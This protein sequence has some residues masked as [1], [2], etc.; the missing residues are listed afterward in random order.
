M[1]D[2]WDKRNMKYETGGHDAHLNGYAIILLE[3]L[4]LL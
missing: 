1:K 4:L 2:R 3:K